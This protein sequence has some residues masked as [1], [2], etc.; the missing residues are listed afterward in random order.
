FGKELKDISPGEAATIAGMIQSPATYAPDR[1]P[2]AA[3]QRRNQVLNAMIQAGAIDDVTAQDETAMPISVASFESGSS[4]FAPYYLDTVNRAL[5]NTQP[6]G[7][8]D[9][10][11]IRVQTTIDPDLQ[12]A[13]ESALRNQLDRLSKTARKE[14]RP[15]G[16]LV[17]IDIHTGHVL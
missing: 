11:N 14:T 1:H 13:A 8:S 12:A 4:E 16:A 9:E 7:E 3:K 15:Q 10:Q 5:E 6:V 17:A 2:D